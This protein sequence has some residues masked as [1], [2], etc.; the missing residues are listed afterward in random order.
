VRKLT[1]K[2]MYLP[3]FDEPDQPAVDLEGVFKP[4]PPG[5]GLQGLADYVKTQIRP[6]EESI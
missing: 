1:P 3:V 2:C 4:L 6:L 5:A